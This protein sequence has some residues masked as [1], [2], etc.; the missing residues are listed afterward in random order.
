MIIEPT[1]LEDCFI[2]KPQV[3]HD[4]RGF[5]METFNLSTFQKKTGL[6]THFV[7]DNLSMSKRG[8]LRGLHF[9][10]GT[11]AQA[12]L[13]QVLKGEILDVVV[14][15]RRN[16]KTFGAHYKIVLNDTNHHQLFIP[17]GFAHGFVTLSKEA[18]FSYKCDNFYDKESENGIIYNDETLSINWELPEDAIILSE[19][20]KQLPAFKTLF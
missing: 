19:K 20:D 4:D 3:F 8:V 16:S 13:I 15:I 11:H 7:Q 18:L 6:K 5:F 2:V 17:K 12:K 1:T 9:Q 10:K 14:D